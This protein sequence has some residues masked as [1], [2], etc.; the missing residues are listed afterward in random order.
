MA[1]FFLTSSLKNSLFLTCWC[2]L[3][4][5]ASHLPNALHWALGENQQTLGDIPQ[6][7]PRTLSVLCSGRR[8]LI[9]AML[10]PMPISF[11]KQMWFQKTRNLLYKQIDYITDLYLF[12]KPIVKV[13]A[14]TPLPSL[15]LP[16][17]MQ[18]LPDSTGLQPAARN[19]R[20]PHPDLELFAGWDI[21][22]HH[23]WKR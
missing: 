11:H 6:A 21:F 23:P 18:N 7:L 16:L 3:L 19:A 12:Y 9:L 17:S 4:K 13:W 8:L 20:C 2:G 14:F 5:W 22:F 10:L 15:K 1:H